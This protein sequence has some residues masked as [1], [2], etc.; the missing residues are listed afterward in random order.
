MSAF[1]LHR[2]DVQRI[3]PEYVRPSIRTQE[4]D[5]HDV[6][7]IVE[8]ET[9]DHVLRRVEDGSAPTPDMFPHTD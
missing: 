6:A 5:D 1:S 8:S 2:R 9:T 3:S 7:G 4:D